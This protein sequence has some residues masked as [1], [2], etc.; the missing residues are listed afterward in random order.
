[1]TDL[2]GSIQKLQI[3]ATQS[4]W[5]QST[6]PCA[7]VA[8]SNMGEHRLGVPELVSRRPIYHEN[9]IIYEWIPLMETVCVASF[10][11]TANMSWNTI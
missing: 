7:Q 3:L 5:R 2:K 10:L 1:M 6:V 8:L 11:G 9:Y 4:Q